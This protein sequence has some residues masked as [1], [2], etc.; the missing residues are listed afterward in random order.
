MET[1][2]ADIELETGKRACSLQLD[3][4]SLKSIKKAAAEFRTLVDMNER[5]CEKLTACFTGKKRNFMCYT[6]TQASCSLQLR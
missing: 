4:A 1:A 5:C 6:I 2:I 3:L